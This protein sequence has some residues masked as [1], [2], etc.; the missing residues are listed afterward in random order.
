MR[1]LLLDTNHAGSLLRDNQQLWA[2]LRS[3]DDAEFA[4]CRPSIGELWFMVFNGTRVVDNRAKLEGMLRRFKVWEFDALAA[5]E[6]G[7]IRAELRRAGTPLPQIDVQIA[8]I[9][10]VNGLTLLTADRHFKAVQG[11][12]V[13]NWL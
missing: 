8:A 9:A 3:D 2:R 1:P 7:Q 10:R 4:F 12:K 11:L 6:F 5:Q 13:E